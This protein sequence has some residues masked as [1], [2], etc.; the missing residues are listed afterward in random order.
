MPNSK[1]LGSNL[2]DPHTGNVKTYATLYEALVAFDKAFKKYEKALTN[3]AK[4]YIM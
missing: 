2:N 1:D 4:R 3:L